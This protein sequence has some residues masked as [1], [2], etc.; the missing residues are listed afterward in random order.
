MRIR[1]K[2]IKKFVSFQMSGCQVGTIEEQHTR[3]EKMIKVAR[4][5][6]D[7]VSSEYSAEFVVQNLKPHIERTD[8]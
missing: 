8:D 2:I 3:Q 1:S 7:G 6:A 4:L 5:S